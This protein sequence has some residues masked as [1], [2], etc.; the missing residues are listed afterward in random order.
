M[1]IYGRPPFTPK[2]RD[3]CERCTASDWV[4]SYGDCSNCFEER[5]TAGVRM[6]T[7]CGPCAKENHLVP[8][9]RTCHKSN[10][11]Y[12]KDTCECFDCY[13]GRGFIPSSKF[14]VQICDNCGMSSNLNSEGICLYC[15]QHYQIQAQ[16]L[17]NVVARCKNCDSLMRAADGLLCENCVGQEVKRGK[18]IRQG[19]L[20]RF[21]ECEGCA[22]QFGI[23]YEQRYETF[24]DNCKRNIERQICTNCNKTALTQDS[25]GWCGECEEKYG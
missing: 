4:N 25:H 22:D 2:K 16:N 24:C 8:I 7:V 10:V 11:K 23:T 17:K 9:C 6:V 14:R 19:N 13:F 12:W 3:V 20:Y 15:Y 1:Y 5:T 21:K 18:N